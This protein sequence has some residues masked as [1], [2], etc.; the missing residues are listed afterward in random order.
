MVN[1]TTLPISTATTILPSVEL[2][3]TDSG[4]ASMDG[5]PGVAVTNTTGSVDDK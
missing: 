2:S 3:I 5:E 1:M 4:T